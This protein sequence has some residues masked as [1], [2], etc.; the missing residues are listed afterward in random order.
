MADRVTLA[1]EFIMDVLEARSADLSAWQGL[2]A[3]GGKP[4]AV[5]R[6]RVTARVALITSDMARTMRQDWAFPHQRAISPRNVARLVNEMKNG[7]FVQGTPL[8]VCI[9]P[10]SK[11]YMVNGNHTCATPFLAN[12]QIQHLA[13]H[14]SWPTRP[15]GEHGAPG[16]QAAFTPSA[17]S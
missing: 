1:R 2:G 7:W 5:E 10:D 9:T 11:L 12:P 13:P 6:T 8:F 15:P 17:P 3:A 16:S 14:H 4:V